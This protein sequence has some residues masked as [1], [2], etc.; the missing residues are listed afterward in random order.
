ARDVLLLIVVSEPNFAQ[1]RRLGAAL[2]EFLEASD[3]Q[4]G[5]ASIGPAGR[6]DKLLVG[7]LAER[8]AKFHVPDFR[9]RLRR[10]EVAKQDQCER[11]R[12]EMTHERHQSPNTTSMTVWPSA[13]ASGNEPS[14]RAGR[15][16]IV[17]A[18]YCLPLTE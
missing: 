11:N 7:Q 1:A 8:R 16:T 5:R 17:R 18:M 2:L 12:K 3:P 9:P 13:I 10:R 4:A 14:S 6:I 15:P